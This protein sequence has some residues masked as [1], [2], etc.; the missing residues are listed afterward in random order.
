MQNASYM[1]EP[2]WSALYAIGSLDSPMD[3]AHRAVRVL[4]G[5]GDVHLVEFFLAGIQREPEL[6]LR[7]GSQRDRDYSAEE[8]TRALVIPLVHG[9]T[10]LGRVVAIL[11]P[12]I[13]RQD[14]VIIVAFLQ[15]VA[16]HLF[17]RYL[18]QLTSEIESDLAQQAHERLL[19]LEDVN[20]RLRHEVE[21]RWHAELQLIAELRE[22]S[23]AIQEIHHRVNN[24]L[25]V[26]LS[27]VSLARNGNGERHHD[28]DV[29][30]QVA[31]RIQLMAAAYDEI[32]RSDTVGRVALGDLLA[33]VARELESGGAARISLGVLPEV[34]PVGA[35]AA[36]PFA[37]LIRELCAGADHSSRPLSIQGSRSQQMVVLEISAPGLHP[38]GDDAT[39]LENRIVQAM[40]DE[41]DAKAECE[42]LADR[43]GVLRISV[44]VTSLAPLREEAI[45]TGVG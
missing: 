38:D 42:T 21:D 17:H 31:S 28:D 22:K 32:L 40:I 15:A 45:A 9:R 6:Q 16:H 14:Q 19:A 4:N 41:L 39:C 26:V 1:H 37:L 36:V 18:L 2:L 11:D 13:A 3:V 27:F 8:R 12:A 7:G 24:N 25:Q 5:I 34:P 33:R 44:P 20:R 23:A 10:E 29:L 43:V 30:A 35:D